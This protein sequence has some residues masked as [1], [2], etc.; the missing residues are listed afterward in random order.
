MAKTN[1]SVVRRQKIRHQIR[2]KI[3]GTQERPRLSVFKSNQFI[4]TQLIDD[5]AGHTIV[6]ATS[7]TLGKKN[8]TIDIS[9]KVGEILAEKAKEKG[10]ESVVF[11]RSGYTYH[12][13]VKA[14]AEA[15]RAKGLKF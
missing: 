8:V 12:G 15:A 1:I 3:S 5:V 6:S 9:T 4:Y 13:N 2:N 10:I 14:V 11:D 7:R